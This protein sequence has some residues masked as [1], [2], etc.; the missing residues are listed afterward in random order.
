MKMKKL[1]PLLAL[2]MGLSTFA[3]CTNTD[4]KIMFEP[5]WNE[6]SNAGDIEIDETL[7]YT[8]DFT[9]NN[10]SLINYTLDYDG[11]YTTHLVVETVN[12][13]LVYT[14]TTNLS[15]IATYTLGTTTKEF[16]DTMT[17]EV[18][19]KSV[20]YGLQPISSKKDIVSH[21]PKS[22]QFDDVTKCYTPRHYTLETNYLDECASGKTAVKR[23]PMEGDPIENEISG[24]YT[25]DIDQKKFTYLDNE[26][27]LAALRCIRN[28]TTS[29]KVNVY[30]PFVNAVQKIAISFA[31]DKSGDFT[32][33][34]ES[35]TITYRS[36]SVVINERNSGV[37]QNVQ[38]AKYDDP[39]NNPLKNII[40]YM[41]TPLSYN[42]GTLQYKLSTTNYVK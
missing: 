30:S 10:S 26:Q 8:V 6:H 9:S 20:G 16:T 3:G 39:N 24:E 1:F 15:L 29:A 5:Y 12:G 21:S 11:T 13:D 2:I 33:N 28:S 41:E 17:S 19:F 22:G 38:I 42:L 31:E 25:F 36:A 32:I 40:L 27:L 23:L 4:Q 7:T 35:K 34:G 14:Y 18:K 37:T